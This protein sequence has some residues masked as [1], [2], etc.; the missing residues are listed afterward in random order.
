VADQAARRDQVREIWAL[1]AVN[2][3][4]NGDDEEIAPMEGSGII[5]EDEMWGLQGFGRRLSRAIVARLKFSNAIG[6]DVESNRRDHPAEGRSEGKPHIP[7]ANH[8]DALNRQRVISV[9]W[10]CWV[11]GINLPCLALT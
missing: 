1:G 4:W 10:V 6:I 7:Q 2:R 3:R 8:S 9:D 11:H 5:R